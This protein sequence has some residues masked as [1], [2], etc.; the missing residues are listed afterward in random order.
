LD[1]FAISPALKLLRAGFQLVLL[2][3]AAISPG[4]LSGHFAG[5]RGCRCCGVVFA[6]ASCFYSRHLPV[7]TGWYHPK[8]LQHV[9]M[10]LV[11]NTRVR[12]RVFS[13]ASAAADSAAQ[14]FRC[15]YF[16]QYFVGSLRPQL[17]AVVQL[18][19]AISGLF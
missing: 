11:F 5:Y 16:Q 2:A 6:W 10:F 7:Q 3:F 9:A 8:V 15:S 19:S 12:L 18:Y 4:W 17:I 14:F 13:P 1:C